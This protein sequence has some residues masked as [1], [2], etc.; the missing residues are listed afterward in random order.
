[1]KKGVGSTGN[2][3][4]HYRNRHRNPVDNESNAN[5]PFKKEEF[6]EK[7][8]EWIVDEMHPYTI[9]EEKGFNNII[10]YLNP[11]TKTKILKQKSIVHLKRKKKK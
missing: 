4:T 7:L 10:K 8:I 2:L 11:S 3:W 6:N 5:H 9:A 1:M